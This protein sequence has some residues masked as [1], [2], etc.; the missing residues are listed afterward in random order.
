M[1]EEK[2]DQ[3]LR[4]QIG[5]AT[6]LRFILSGYAENY[7]QSSVVVILDKLVAETATQFKVDEEPKP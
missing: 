5:I 1:S 4:N 6:A 7:M 3:V 2:L